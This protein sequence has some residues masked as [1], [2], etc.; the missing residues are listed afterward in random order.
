MK[1]T[2]PTLDKI[3]EPQWVID[4]ASIQ[5]RLNKDAYWFVDINVPEPS[6]LGAGAFKWKTKVAIVSTGE[7]KPGSD[8]SFAGAIELQGAAPRAEAASGSGGASNQNHSVAAQGSRDSKPGSAVDQ[9]C[10]NRI[11]VQHPSDPDRDHVEQTEELAASTEKAFADEI[12][13]IDDPMN[14][15]TAEFKVRM[16]AAHIC[17]QKR[18]AEVQGKLLAAV[19]QPSMKAYLQYVV[20]WFLGGDTW[21]CTRHFCD[22]FKV[23][24]GAA[25]EYVG[26]NRID[27]QSCPRCGA[28]PQPRR[29]PQDGPF[30]WT[31]QCCVQQSL[32]QGVL[33]GPVY[34]FI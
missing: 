16:Y 32:V 23:V 29:A 17:E 24:Q 18:Q 25:P 4:P 3:I 19:L 9:P 22:V 14:G 30:P 20:M 11:L 26:G 8:Q 10:A 21:A 12:Y 6:R 2:Q 28:L 13:Y 1:Q 34:G 15:T 31:D 5:S 27:L 7:M 33:E